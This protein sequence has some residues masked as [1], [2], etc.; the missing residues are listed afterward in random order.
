M[1]DFL[2][3]HNQQVLASN[4]SKTWDTT[5][6][7]ENWTKK[8]NII[9]VWYISDKNEGRWGR[10][11]SSKEP[12]NSCPVYQTSFLNSKV[13]AHA[14]TDSLSSSSNLK[15]WKSYLYINETA[16]LVSWKNTCQNTWME[17]I[18]VFTDGIFGGWDYW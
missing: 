14:N 12:I 1:K 18:S 3:L 17:D 7:L 16:K 15:T 5:N 6:V 8:Y 10:R 11:L 2:A 9:P 13:N 4:A